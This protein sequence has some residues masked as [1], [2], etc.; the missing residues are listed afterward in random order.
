MEAPRLDDMGR[1]PPGIANGIK[2]IRIRPSPNPLGS[3]DLR[4]PL[5]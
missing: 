2:T 5:S 4:L 1:R 3:V